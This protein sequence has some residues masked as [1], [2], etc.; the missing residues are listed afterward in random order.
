M[1]NNYLLYMSGGIYIN[2]PFHINIKCVIFGAL[3]SLIYW[4]CPEKK[5]RS[6]FM[7]FFIMAAA[8]IAMV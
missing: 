2:R 4:F 3:I 7:I 5:D 6:P 1:F 8:Y